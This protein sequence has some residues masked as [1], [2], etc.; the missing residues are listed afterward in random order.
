MSQCIVSIV[1]ARPQ[2]IKVAALCREFST[3][4][5]I[6]H[7]LIHSGQHYDKGLSATFFDELEIPEP[8]FHLGVGSGSHGQQTGEILKRLDPILQEIR[9]DA[10]LV[11]GDTNTTLAGALCAAKL[12]FPLVHI[13]AGERSYNR[14]MPEEINRIL[15]DHMADLLFCSSEKAVDN[16]KREGITQRV[17]W[18]GDVMYDV[19]LES[20]AK[21]E[22]KSNI[23]ERLSLKAKG[24]ALATVHRAENTDNPTHLQGIFQG[25]MML[26]Q[27][28]TKV[29]IPLHPR[30]RSALSSLPHYLNPSPQNMLVIEPISYFDMLIMEKNA[31]V[32]LTD[33]GGVQKEA[34]FLRIPCVTL[35]AE[36]EWVETVETNW[37]TLVDCDPNRIVQAA[38]GAK[39]GI[40]SVSPYG[41]GHAAE[42]IVKLLNGM[43]K[44]K[45]Y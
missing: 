1:G 7:I 9:P 45:G 32:V 29:V 44:R 31:Q 28:G 17:H 6:R 40:E 23:L 16:L 25:L 3:H 12:R 24:Y 13:E 4:S 22:L 11:Y 8:D 35:R 42:K 26:A 15:V 19:V 36:T 39:P 27:T 18:V 41:D 20:I 14:A 37:N 38:L 10:V 5:N 21:T 33:S 30:T 43:T 2:F 34:F